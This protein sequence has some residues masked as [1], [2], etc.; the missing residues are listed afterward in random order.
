MYQ[1]I[2]KQASDLYNSLAAAGDS[3]LLQPEEEETR[4]EQ[5]ASFITDKM[6]D[7]PHSDN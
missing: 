5:T 2:T 3:K 4:R 1:P 7:D 6:I